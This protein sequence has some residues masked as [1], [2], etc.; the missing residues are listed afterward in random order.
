MQFG[1]IGINYKSAGLDIRDRISFPDSRKIEFL[2][3]AQKLGA[4]QCM[5][6]STCNRSEIFFFFKE[7]EQ[8][9]RIRQLYCSMFPEVELE[10]YLDGFTGKDAVTYLYRITAGLESL[11][12]GEDQILGQVKEALDF[13]RTMGCS[14]KELN[15][16]VR[17][18][19][20]CAKKIK[21]ELKISEKPLSVS[22]VG[23]R[24]L[25]EKGGIK[26]K[27][28][29]VIGSGKTAVLALK[30]IYEYEASKVYVCSRTRA[31]ANALKT[32]FPG[33]ETVAFEERYRVMEDCDTV[34]SATASPHLVV[35]CGEFVLKRP[36]MFLDLAAPRDIDTKL[37]K[38]EGAEL[39][40]LDTL[41]EIVAE[42]QKERERLTEI[43]RE[44]ISADAEETMSWLFESRMDATIAS[45]QNR[46]E[47]IVEDS[48]EYLNRKLELEAREQKILK[49]TLKAALH[50]LVRE[51]IE[52]LRQLETV[53]KQ[54]EYKEMVEK[55][56]QF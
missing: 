27:K 33:L 11:V 6:L 34:I 38:E 36:M 44:W 48:Y 31:H 4:G 1:Y 19:V 32:E 25:E 22:Y 42:N 15:K 18:A 28:V 47:E 16:V 51:P 50:R 39:I 55:L 5:V 9:K 41:Q 2:Q 54:D 24:L 46:C 45:L 7:E 52:E 37:T 3:S 26:G 53:E 20:T 13:S 43:S 23:I 21:T 10:G 30:Y 29:L 56:F 17:D 40:N 8:L 14:G 35:K 12:L 49:K